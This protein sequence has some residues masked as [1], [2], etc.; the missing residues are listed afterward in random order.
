MARSHEF[1]R[2]QIIKP[3]DV[4]P[5]QL[6]GARALLGW[7]QRQL[8][9]TAGVGLSTVK[10]AEV[11]KHD[12]SPRMVDRLR[13]ALA[14][15]GIEFTSEGCDGDHGLGVR[16]RSKRPEL[17]RRPFKIGPD[18]ALGFLV[19]WRSR[20]IVV[21]IGVDAI[22][23]LEQLESQEFTVLATA[24]R[25]HEGEI[26]TATFKALQAKRFDDSGFV[27]LGQEDFEHTRSDRRSGNQPEDAADG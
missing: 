2:I 3:S 12:L 10:D 17:V 8:A 18:A 13:D 23:A 20:K 4:S 1:E 11:G 6:R 7:S 26:L 5:A 9:E 27:V 14:V 24:F 25:R 22:M 15:A 19:R 21:E 16:Y